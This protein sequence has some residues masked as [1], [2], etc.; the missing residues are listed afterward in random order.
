VTSIIEVLELFLLNMKLDLLLNHLGLIAFKIFIRVILIIVAKVL[1]K[2]LNS[3]IEILLMPL[4]REVL[5]LGF[6]VRQFLMKLAHLSRP[7]LNSED[8]P[9]PYVISM[10]VGFFQDLLVT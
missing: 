10:A 3:L 2:L 5:F 7:E 8:W 9:L 4:I 1:I 6:A